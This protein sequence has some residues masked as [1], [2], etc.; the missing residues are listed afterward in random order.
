SGQALSGVLGISRT[1]VWKHIKGLRGMGYHIGASPSKGYSLRAGGE[2]TPF[3]AVEISSGLTTEFIGRKI[4]FHA[5]LQSTNLKAFELGRAGEPEG[6]SV[7]ADAQTG[8]KGRIGRRWV[9]PPS[10]NLYTSIILRPRISP[11]SAHMLTLMAGLSVAE[12]IGLFLGRRPVVKWPNDVLIGSKKAAGILMEMDAEPDRVNFVV[13]GIGVNINMAPEDMPDE[14]R[15]IAT[16]LKEKTGADISRAEFTMALYASFEKWYKIFKRDGFPPII[17]EWKSYFGYEGKLVR[18]V[19]FNRTIE[20]IC[21]GIGSDGALL[22]RLPTG[23]LER[24]ISGD[25]LPVK[26]V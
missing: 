1:A 8:G 17:N 12:A 23:A 22:V 19:N 14:I 18:V 21:A 15:N 9:S 24:V 2:E 10:V 20:G 25:V 16:S 26:A 7:I 11:A 5:A 6:T 13:A 3:N 4:F